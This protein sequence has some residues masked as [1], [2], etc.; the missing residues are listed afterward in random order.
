MPTFR[1]AKVTQILAERSGLQRV[2]VRFADPDQRGDRAYVL[3]ELT[4]RVAVDD[5]VIV[6][7]TAVDLGLGTGGWHF[8]HWNLNTSEFVNPGDDHIMKMRYTSLQMDVGAAELTAP[9]S[10]DGDLSGVPVIVCSVH[11]LAGVAMAALRWMHPTARIVY[12]MTDDAALPIAL[13]DLVH[14]F[15]Q[16][17]ICDAT[18]TSGHAFGGT[19]EAV[20]PASALGLARNELGADAIVLGMGPG[21]VGTGST[22]G[23]TAIEVAGLIDD[24][25]LS[26]GDP[27]LALRVSG[28]DQRERHRGISHH[29]IT[30]LQ[31]CHTSPRIADLADLGVDMSA[32]DDLAQLVHLPVPP[33]AGAILDAMDVHITSMGRDFDADPLF[34]HAGVRSAAVA[35]ELI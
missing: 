6:N 14:D 12:V 20:T 9:A 11:S 30:A 10:A 7:T 1:T 25:A 18:V 35:S 8:V 5:D 4:G 2:R 3:T 13:S 28:A 23:T 19:L 29:S 26:G 33:D 15:T 31:R 34:F 27:V 22:L 24:V 17:G 21:V 32:V 16:R